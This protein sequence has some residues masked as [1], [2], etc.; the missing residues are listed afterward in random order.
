MYSAIELPTPGCDMDAWAVQ[1][2]KARFTELLERCLAEGPQL[3][4]KRGQAAAVLI[5]IK[6]WN[7]MQAAG[8]PSLKALLLEPTP[9]HEILVTARGRLKMRPR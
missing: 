7:A 9:R 4:T 3:V 8:K 6:Q 1:D 5:P 2:A